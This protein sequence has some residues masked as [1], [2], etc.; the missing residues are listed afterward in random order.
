[1]II[2]KIILKF[3]NDYVSLLMKF[4]KSTENSLEDHNLGDKGLN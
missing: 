1:M 2:V 3:I 4:Q